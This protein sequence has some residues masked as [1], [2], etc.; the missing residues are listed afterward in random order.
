MLSPSA[1]A[2]AYT[3][4]ACREAAKSARLRYVR[5][6]KPG[7]TRKKQGKSYTYFTPQG[8]RITAKA[9][10][11]R[12]NALAIP[13]AYTDVWICPDA[14]GHVQ[15]T[16]RDDRGRKQYRYHPKWAEVRNGT[17]FDQLRLFGEQLPKI[18]RHLKADLAK[19]GLPKER[20]LAAILQLMD[21]TMIRVGNKEYAKTNK[22]YGLTTMR[23][24]H[25]E[26]KGE[27]IR[28]DF[29][30]KSGK[31]WKL[32][33]KDRRIANVIKR[34]EEIPGH[35]LFH[36]LDDAGEKRPVSSDDVNSYLQE[37]TG[38]PFTAKDFRTWSATE[39]AL[40][41]LGGI[42]PAETKTETKRQLNE[43]IKQ[44]AKELGH[45]PA[46]CR[47]CYIHPAVIERFS[48]GK[49]HRWLACRRDASSHKM[50]CAFLKGC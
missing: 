44:I 46:I 37:I 39:K 6:D 43:S 32:D 25:V 34:C 1:P 14:N 30:G 3:E 29:T 42:E 10:I 11:E 5:D 24:R 26:V 17:K 36:Y 40:L 21:T 18:R 20:V 8:K 19:R 49:L 22:S 35:E 41:L 31:H 45:T 23:K 16:G 48:N 27:T 38:Q 50:V 2:T 7:I 47:K 13:P 15:A 4:T 9:E 33:I 28:F 12:I